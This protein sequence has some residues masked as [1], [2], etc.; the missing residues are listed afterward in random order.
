MF[1]GRHSWWVGIV[2]G[3]WYRLVYRC[4]ERRLGMVYQ[5]PFARDGKLRHRRLEGRGM[6]VCSKPVRKVY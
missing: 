1:G 4:Y 5:D 3:K 6:I 2:M